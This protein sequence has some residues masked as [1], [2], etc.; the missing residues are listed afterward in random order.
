M[1]ATIGIGVLVM[2]RHVA[3]VRRLW[4]REELTLESGSR[5]SAALP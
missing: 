4:R 1:L 2:I 3:N 5:N